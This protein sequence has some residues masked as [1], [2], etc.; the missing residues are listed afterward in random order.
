MD[1]KAY[2]IQ[3]IVMS[4]KG[5]AQQKNCEHF[6]ARKLEHE[7]WIRSIELFLRWL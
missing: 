1:I 2:K 7:Y 4:A 6:P 5:F 3:K